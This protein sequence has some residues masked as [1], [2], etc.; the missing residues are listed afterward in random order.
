AEQCAQKALSI[1]DA[2]PK[3][4]DLMGW[5]H[6]YQRDFDQAIEYEKKA[7]AL[8]PNDHWRVHCLGYMMLF[9][10]RYEDAIA[11]EKRSLR[12]SPSEGQCQ[13]NILGWAYYRSK[14]Y[15]E[16]IAALK[17]CIVLNPQFV[18]PHL[19]LIAI[20]SELE[21]DEEAKHHAE[22]VLRIDPEFSIEGHWK[23]WPDKIQAEVERMN[24]A[25]RKAGLK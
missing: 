25:W 15:N 5:L 19:G 9:T 3:A 14:Q 11:L 16:G 6:Y 12:L 18:L 8:A 20:Y 7:V 24:R 17:K 1:D 23:L 13:L 2:N 4:N 21:R 22:Q 10:G